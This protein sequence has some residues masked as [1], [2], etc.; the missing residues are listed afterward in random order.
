[1]AEMMN[2]GENNRDGCEKGRQEILRYLAA[3]GIFSSGFLD[4]NRSAL[5]RVPW[6]VSHFFMSLLKAFAFSILFFV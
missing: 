6:A 1:M 4:N 5:H 2:I 3:P